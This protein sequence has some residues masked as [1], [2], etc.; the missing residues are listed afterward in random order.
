MVHVHVFRLCR[1]L[2]QKCPVYKG[3]MNYACTTFQHD[4]NAYH[5]RICSANLG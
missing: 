4:D 5:E 1:Y 3:I 2:L